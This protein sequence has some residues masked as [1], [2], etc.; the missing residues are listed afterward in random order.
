MGERV[1][2]FVGSLGGGGAERVCVTVANGLADRGFDVRLVVISLAGAVYDDEID[3]G[4]TVVDLGKPHARESP[5]ALARCL[6]RSPPSVA[7][8]FNYEIAI[9]LLALRTALRQE[10]SL[11]V[12]VINTL[13]MVAEDRDSLWHSTIV[14]GLATRCFPYMDRLVAQS[15]G[16]AEDLVESY[17]IDPDS[18]TVINNPIAEEIARHAP[19]TDGADAAPRRASGP[20]DLDEIL[21]VGRLEEQKGVHHLIDAFAGLRSSRP[22][23]RLRIL[24][25][26]PLEEDLRSR[27]AAAGVADAITF[28]GFVDDVWRYYR[29]ADVTALPSLYEGFPNVLVESLALGTPAVAFDCPSG[30]AEIV[31][32]DVNGYLVEYADVDDLRRQLDRAL[33]RDWDPAAVVRTAEPYSRDAIVDEYAS[34]VTEFTDGRG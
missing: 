13:S 9:V 7:L 32:D 18:I 4:V 14:L 19:S 10:F 29:D 8:A 24:G 1:D 28:A 15:R 31:D 25:R 16:M 11:L 20:A 30:P 5:L 12:R 33:A 26:G 27:A 34:L 23:C 21:F 17:G 6:R 22:D 3:D 2:L